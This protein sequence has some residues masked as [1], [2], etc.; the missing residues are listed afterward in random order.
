MLAGLMAM[1]AAAASMYMDN[2][3]EKLDN[4][5]ELSR[6]LRT[7]Q[8]AQMLQK[9][10]VIPSFFLYGEG[11]RTV[12]DR[13][14]HL[15]SIDHRSRP[16]DWHIRPHSHANLNHVFLIHSGGGEMTAESAAVPMR[17]P[18]L[19]FLPSSVV[20]GFDFQ[21]ETC[22]MVLT[23]S[24]AYLNDIVGRSA[25]FPGLF[26]TPRQVEIASARQAQTLLRGFK[27]LERELMWNAPAHIAAIEVELLSVLVCAVRLIPNGLAAEPV[28]HGS[29]VK[30]VARFREVIEKD[31]RA[32]PA[33]K[34]YLD[35]LGTTYTRLHAA[36]M[37]VVGRT[38][39]Q[40]IRERMLL[41]AKRL[42]IY[43]NMTI[44]ETAYHLGFNDP[45]YFS[46]FF[47]QHSGHAP[48]DFRK[49]HSSG[50]AKNAN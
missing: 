45:A 44:T 17:A 40:L 14:L 32:N 4:F 5:R 26:A 35:G 15:E 41:E 49:R 2:L 43:S 27:R 10:S 11:P 20:H 37:K 46:R 21:S 8:T 9:H 29:E 22:G 16:A 1:L 28:K 48:R 36:C 50:G 38:P 24:D 23:L 47:A 19:I 30:L 18:C 34:S 33:I 31:F 6:H 13:F 25:D 42:L 39:L 7:R 12:D 3:A